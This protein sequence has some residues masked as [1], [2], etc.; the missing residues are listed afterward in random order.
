M[1]TRAT[2][3]F[4]LPYGKA[5]ITIYIHCDGYP[6]GAACYFWNMYQHKSYK[7]SL[8]DIFIKA[9][10]FD[11]ELIESHEIYANIEYQYYMDSK[12]F[13]VAKKTESAFEDNSTIFFEG[14]FAQF[15]NQY[16]HL[17]KSDQSFERFY[18]LDK[19]A[20]KL[21]LFPY[22][23][24]SDVKKMSVDYY[25]NVLEGY[26]QYQQYLDIWSA[27]YQRLKKLK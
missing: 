27:E 8:A 15:I 11:A 23:T 26:T 9:N 2:Y 10:P 17:L 19:A 4:E 13:L 18:L 12:G 21:A 24:L 22:L 3:S 20:R 5:T 6:E 1:S 25:R 7:G 16:A 14:H